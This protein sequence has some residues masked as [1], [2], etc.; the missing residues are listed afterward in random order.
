MKNK[1]S[2]KMVLY[3]LRN[4]NGNFMTHFFGIVFPNI[5]CLLLSK[6]VGSQVPDNVRQEVLT[7][8]TLSMSLVMPMAIMLLGYGALYSREVERGIPLRMR[9]FGYSEKSEITAKLIAHLIFLTIAFIIFSLVQMIAMDIPKP[10]FSSLICLILSLYLLGIIFLVIAH[11][12]AQIFKKF[13]ITFGVSMFLYFMIMMIT[14]MMGIETEQL[15]QTLQKIAGM[16]PMTYVS[17]DF[18]SFWQGGSY[19]FMPYIQSLL[20]LGAIAGILLLYSMHK[21]RRVI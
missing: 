17:N 13:S 14:G 8:I 12:F 3:E 20:F 7:S 5:M 15:P 9:L 16:F 19:N 18:A 21:N 6:T 2:F 10:A 1:C 4:I 11:S